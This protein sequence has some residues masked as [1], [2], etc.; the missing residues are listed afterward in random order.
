[1]AFHEKS[2]QLERATKTKEREKMRKGAEN[3]HP[4]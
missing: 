2:G 3:Q 4:T 1:M